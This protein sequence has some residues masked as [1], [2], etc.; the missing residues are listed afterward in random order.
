MGDI[1]KTRKI[2]V[3]VEKPVI[4]RPFGVNRP[5]RYEWQEK[6]IYE[7]IIKVVNFSDG[8]SYIVPENVATEVHN[9][10]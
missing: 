7:R 9:R 10:Q 2:R 1:T 3:M 6:N 8:S 4:V 5:A